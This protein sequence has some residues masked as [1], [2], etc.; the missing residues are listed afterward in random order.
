MLYEGCAGQ[1][2]DVGGMEWPHAEKRACK[3]A[4]APLTEPL[5]CI[6]SQLV[7]CWALS[8]LA[9]QVLSYQSIAGSNIRSV[10]QQARAECA[11]L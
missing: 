1:V 6:L 7:L 5:C 9:L 8:A 11:A 3:L 4:P 10:R 2:H